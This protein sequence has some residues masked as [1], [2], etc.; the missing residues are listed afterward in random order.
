[1]TNEEIQQLEWIK[2]KI[3]EIF[4]Y[5]APEDRYRKFCYRIFPAIDAMLMK[6]KKENNN[7]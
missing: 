3:E 6:A 1:M 4:G 5:T 2:H 7:E